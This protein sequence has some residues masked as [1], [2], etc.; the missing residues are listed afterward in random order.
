MMFAISVLDLPFTAGKQEVKFEKG[1]MTL[2]PS[3][4]A[5]A[6]H[7]EVKPAQAGDKVQILVSQN[8]YRNGDR[9][10]DEN[11]ERYDKFVTEEFVIHTVYGCQV[12]VTNPTPSRQRLSV[13]IQVPT[14]AIAV[15]NGQPTK[16]IPIELEPYRTQVIDFL[17]YFP[18]PGQFTVFPV[19]VAKSEMMVAAG[20]PFTFNVVPKPTKLDTESWEYV[21]QNGSAE[22]VIN[23]MNRENVNSL[24]LA[25]IA[26]RMKDRDFFES[27]T[28]SAVE[29]SARV[30]CDALVLW[31]AP[32]PCSR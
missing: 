28:I 7:E 12:V 18:R 4:T 25:K 29:G 2:I 22:Q 32:Q 21:S 15:A 20:N 30:Q 23:L 31:G 3:T 16:T 26:F 8:F 19:H 11:G 14:G 10:R 9:Y 24:D 13:L 1:R 17:F 6:F 5:L 27:K